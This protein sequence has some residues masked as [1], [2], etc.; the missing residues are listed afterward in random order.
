MNISVLDL[1]TQ[2]TFS[3]IGRNKLHELK[4]SVVGF[5]DYGT[6]SYLAF[7]ES[8][9][10]KLEERLKQTDLVVGFNIKGFDLVVLQP[11]L[12]TSVEEL[13][14]LDLLEEIKKVRGHRVTLQ[15]LA[16][17]TL[18]EAKSGSGWDAVRLFHEGK[19]EELKKYCLNDV[20]ITKAIFDYGRTHKRVF[21]RS[22]RDFQTYE[23]PV[24]WGERLDEFAKKQSN[25]PSSLF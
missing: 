20:R 10:P 1:E 8:E 4:V 5:Y 19:L 17:A 15:S 22:E 14:V 9:I 7:E 21:F 13:P 12:L 6:D 3:E 11:Y 18:Q 23:I 2:K 24:T 25:F 16:I